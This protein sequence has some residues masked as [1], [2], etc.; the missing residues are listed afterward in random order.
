MPLDQIANFVR[1]SAAASVAAADTTISVTDASTFPDPTSGRGEYNVVIW[2]VNNHPRPDQDADAEVI[3]V[4]G[5][6]TTNNDLTVTRGQEGTTAETHPDGSAIHLA[7]TQKFADDIVAGFIEDANKTV[8]TS[9]LADDAVDSTAIAAGAVVQAAIANG[10]VTVDEL[11]DALGTTSTNKIPGT[12]YFKNAN[13]ETLE[14]DAT[15]VGATRQGGDLSFGDWETNNHDAVKEV[16]IEAGVQT[17]GNT[18]ASISVDLDY[19]GDGAVNKNADIAL[20]D[21]SQNSGTTVR[22]LRSFKIPPGGA[23][24]VNNDSDPNGNNEFRIETEWLL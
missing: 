22:E 16:E 3:R 10:A 19:N 5:R 17:D 23:Y 7:Y 9:N 4:T 13:V 12:T 11:A 18:A 20:A 1:G 6:D 8:D 24:R 15:L 2:D 21:G 14:A